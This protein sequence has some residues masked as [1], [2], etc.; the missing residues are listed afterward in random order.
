MHVLSTR[1]FLPELYASKLAKHRQWE[2][3]RKLEIHAIFVP[4]SA[5]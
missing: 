5:F 3:G 1:L 4:W 2:T